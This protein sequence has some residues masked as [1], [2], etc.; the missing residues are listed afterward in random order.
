MGKKMGKMERGR[1]ENEGDRGEGRGTEG[2]CTCRARK[3]SVRFSC[4]LQ[5]KSGFMVTSLALAREGG[6][7]AREGEGKG[8]GEGRGVLKGRE[9]RR[10]GRVRG[11]REEGGE[12]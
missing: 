8:K 6:E 3:S 11:R 4:C 10:E 12:G 2:E 9:G 7:G 5:S 1:Q